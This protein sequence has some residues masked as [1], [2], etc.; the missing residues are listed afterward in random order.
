LDF[1]T[2]DVDLK[3]EKKTTGGMTELPNHPD[4]GTNRRNYPLH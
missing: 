4:H 1:V 3:E 2:V